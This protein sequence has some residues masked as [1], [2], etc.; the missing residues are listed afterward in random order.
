MSD[1]LTPEAPVDAETVLSALPAPDAVDGGSAEGTAPAVV[2]AERFNGLMSKYQSEKSEWET[3]VAALTSDLQSLTATQQE[4]PMSD[5]VSELKETVQTL[6][7]IILSDREEAARAKVLDEYPEAA[8]FADL[9][10]GNNAAEMKQVAAVIAE[11]VKGIVGASAPVG[12]TGDTG[13]TTEAQAEGTQVEGAVAATAPTAPES[14][15]TVAVTGG[16]TFADAVREAIVNEDFQAFI[17]AKFQEQSH[18]LT[19]VA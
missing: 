19:R 7:S 12:E 13:V 8:P 14:G 3:K 2:P 5:E 18:A 16:E 15:G 1:V 10:V 11:R 17:N 9:I 4:M 6:T